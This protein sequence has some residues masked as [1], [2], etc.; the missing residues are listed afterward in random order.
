MELRNNMRVYDLRIPVR[1]HT[2]LAACALVAATLL[3][4]SAPAAA[5]AFQDPLDYPA[6]AVGALANRPLM[7]VTS[8]G[9]RLVAVGSRGLIIVSDDNGASWKQAR[10]PVQSDLLAVQ[11]PTAS[12]GWAVGHDGVILHSA[13]GGASWEKQLDGRSAA[14]RYKA[15][16]RKQRETAGA[17]VEH[18]IAQLELNFK[19]GPALPYLDVWFADARRGFVVGAFGMIAATSDGGQTWEPWLHR[20]DNPEFLNLNGIRGIG[21]RIYIAGERGMVFSLD[22]AGERFEKSATGYA[23]SFFGIVGNDKVLLS[24]GLRGN[25]YRSADQ[26][27]SWE[28]VKLPSDATIM[29][30]SAR[31][32]SGAFVLANSAGQLM[33][34]DASAR[35]F[36]RVHP[37]SGMRYTSVAALD[38]RIVLTGLGGVRIEPLPAG[39]N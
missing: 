22:A 23:G 25:V 11:F 31:P 6:R 36:T 19:A 20:I 21:G 34:G 17:Q 5:S 10:V 9:S 8:A 3:F 26:G 4:A 14:T 16:Y 2:G 29:G 28:P 13:D 30:G 35:E 37:L 1:A 18:A 24:F 12:D 7:A 38:G 27:K 15:F 32:E 39:A 33:L